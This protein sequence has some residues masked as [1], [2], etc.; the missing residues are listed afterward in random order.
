[1]SDSVVITGITGQDGAYLAKHLLEQ[2]YRVIGLSRPVSNP[3]YHNLKRLGIEDDVEK[4]TADLTDRGSIE[5]V[6]LDHQPSK[7]FNLAAQ[8]FVSASFECPSVT[9]D[10]NSI[11][12]LRVLEAIRN[13]SPHTRFYQASTSEMFG[14]VQ[15]VPQNEQTPFYPR[16]P[17]GVSKLFAH[18]MTVNFRESYD[19]YA[20][21]G[22]LFNHESPLRGA[23]FVTR[24]VVSHLVRLRLGLSTDPLRLGNLNAERDWGHAADYVK[25]MNLMLDQEVPEDFVLATGVTS[26]IRDLVVLAAQCLGLD[27]EWIGE[28][29]DEKGIDKSTQKVIVEVD[30][31]FYR[32]CEV[33]QLLG[34]P[35]KA[36]RIL[37]WEREYTFESLIDEMCKWESDLLSA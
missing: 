21:S 18:W 23:Q 33:D 35:A 30:P 9:C 2:D 36:Q 14:K 26:S 28:G 34:D 16:S 22:I 6:L 32:P 13:F 24:K 15:S 31:N 37:G 7:Y 10:I 8:S 29:L 11:A 12:V 25:G 19:M 27:I 1:M 3:S 5:R 20:V 17:Y 4:R